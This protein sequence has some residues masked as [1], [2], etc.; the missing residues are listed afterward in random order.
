MSEY[1][2]NAFALW[3]QEVKTCAGLTLKT[4]QSNF[5]KFAFDMLSTG[6]VTPSDSHAFYS[7]TL[8]SKLAGNP[9]R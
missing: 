3:N 6:V 5:D 4:S 1:T 2:N 8:L 7:E 9:A